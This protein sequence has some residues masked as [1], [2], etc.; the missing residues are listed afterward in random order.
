MRASEAGAR[1]N[2]T[3]STK[4]AESRYLREVQRAIANQ[5]RYPALARRRGDTGTVVVSFVVERSGR[6]TGVGIAKGS[7]SATLDSAA[8]DTLKRLRRFKPI[9]EAIARNRWPMRVP[10]RFSLR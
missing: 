1:T 3:A 9:P 4:A 7:G 10:I 5:R 6:I 8:L 2:G